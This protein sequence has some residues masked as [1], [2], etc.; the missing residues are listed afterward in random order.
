MANQSVAVQVREIAKNR[1]CQQRLWS[2]PLSDVGILHFIEHCHSERDAPDHRQNE[3][4]G[5][6]CIGYPEPTILKRL[7][8]RC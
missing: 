5:A 7:T 1:T 3:Q 2:H 6:L 8:C 4:T